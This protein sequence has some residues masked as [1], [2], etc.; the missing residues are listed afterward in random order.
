MYPHMLYCTQSNRFKPPKNRE[1]LQKCSVKERARKL[2]PDASLAG[3][4][5]MFA[6]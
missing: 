3:T 1:L 6:T 2:R 4:L 5:P